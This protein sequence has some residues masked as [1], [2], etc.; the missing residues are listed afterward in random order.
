MR[1]IDADEYKEKLYA[2]MPEFDEEND[3]KCIEGQTIF[4]CIAT[5]DDMPTITPPP[6]APLTMEEARE[7]AR[8]KL[9][10]WYGRTFRKEEA[11]GQTG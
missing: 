11:C 6:N 9:R 2:M 7:S 3:K 8:Q 4:F 1:L 10:R 5:L